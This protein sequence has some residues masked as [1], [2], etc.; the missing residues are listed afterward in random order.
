MTQ[1]LK[2]YCE[3]TTTNESG[4]NVKLSYLVIPFTRW[5]FTAYI[6]SVIN[7]KIFNALKSMKVYYNCSIAFTFFISFIRF[8]LV[9]HVSAVSSPFFFFSKIDFVFSAVLCLVLLNFLFYLSLFLGS[10]TDV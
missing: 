8:R 9:E 3:E 7:H 2:K 4:T 5:I 6:E 10:S 1:K